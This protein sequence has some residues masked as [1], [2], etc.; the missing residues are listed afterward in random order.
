MKTSENMK[1]TINSASQIIDVTVDSMEIRQGIH[2]SVER[3]VSLIKY[4]KFDAETSLFRIEP[5]V[6]PIHDLSFNDIVAQQPDLEAWACWGHSYLSSRT[7]D[8]ISEKIDLHKKRGDSEEKIASACRRGVRLFLQPLIQHLRIFFLDYL[9]SS[10]NKFPLSRWRADPPSILVPLDRT[11]DEIGV[12]DDLWRVCGERT[13]VQKLVKGHPRIRYSKGAELTINIDIFLQHLRDSCQR[14]PNFQTSTLRI[15]FWVRHSTGEYENRRLGRQETECNWIEHEF[16]HLVA[17]RPLAVEYLNSRTRNLP[18]HLSGISTFIGSYL[19]GAEVPGSPSAQLSLETAINPDIFFHRQNRGVIPQ[20]LN[21]YGDKKAANK[22]IDFLDW[23]L[24]VRYSEMDDYGCKVRLSEYSHVF[25]RSIH[26]AAPSRASSIRNAMP[27]SMMDLLRRIICEGHTFSEWSWAQSAQT[28]LHGY[29]ADW[30]EVDEYTIDKSDPNC[31]WRRRITGQGTVKERVVIEMWSPVRWVALLIKLILP[32]RTGQLR[33]LDSG[34]CDDQIFEY[35]MYYAESL[36]DEEDDSRM[37]RENNISEPLMRSRLLFELNGKRGE[38]SKKN[39]LRPYSN[40]IIRQIESL[41]STSIFKTHANTKSSRILTQTVLYINSNKTADNRDGASKGFEAAWPMMPYPLN[42]DGGRPDFKSEQDEYE[43]LGQLAQNVYYWIGLLRR[44]QQKYNPVDRLTPW[45]ELVKNLIIT[46]KTDVQAST[47]KPAVFLFREPCAVKT[48]HLPLKDGN[49]QQAW[50]NLNKEAQQRLE[51]KYINSIEQRPI[52]LV[53]SDLCKTRQC[54]FDLHS[55]RVSVI[56]ALII[57]AKVDAKIVQE[58]VGHSRLIMTLYYTKPS[59][60]QVR[61]ELAKG[62]GKL[63]DTKFESEVEFLKGATLAQLQEKSACNDAES[64]LASFGSSHQ[65]ST[66]TWVQMIDGICP[67]GANSTTD[68]NNSSAYGCFNGGRL[69]KERIES[70]RHSVYAPVEGGPQNCANCR[71]FVTGPS[72]LP[73]L[74]SKFNNVSFHLDEA[75]TSARSAQDNLRELARDIYGAELN[76]S[77]IHE[78]SRLR[79]KENRA[80][81]LAEQAVN[82]LAMQATTLANLY[83]LIQRCKDLMHVRAS[84]TPED[85]PATALVFSG[86]QRELD[87]VI[88]ECTSELEQLCLIASDAEIYPELDAGK[89]IFRRSQLLDYKLIR[90]GLPAFFMSLTE[91]EQMLVGNEFMRRMASILH[92]DS[93]STRFKDV[94]LLLEGEEPMLAI[95]GIHRTEWQ[96][97]IGGCKDFAL[98][99]SRRIE[100]SPGKLIDYE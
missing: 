97:F 26:T 21:S 46:P 56:T 33:V 90:E 95:L 14:D 92:P 77:P 85:S 36:L 28:S 9:C 67:V 19:A 41:T 91:Y 81:N 75:R 49:L 45:T 99:Q 62:L 82:K 11:A 13:A 31:V 61:D 32:T 72:Y 15:P 29:G 8:Y 96:N 71:W 87:T 88:K 83:R 44:W 43:W 50:W 93:I 59:H 25:Q 94:A 16:P 3:I 7:S 58:L 60:S 66:A 63:S 38:Q 37:W 89:S 98:N 74:V 70:S 40:G 20:C 47:Y 4:L 51:S 5:S 34:E 23:V 17:W 84:S 48:P 55:L 52:R 10:E 65:R 76:N 69:L 30:F 100:F 27:F 64:L 42:A 78:L 80:I 22:V 68:P 35:P 73:A 12:R 1:K 24:D 53:I 2:I 57:E 79:E 86:S 18:A 54:V 6:G 39:S